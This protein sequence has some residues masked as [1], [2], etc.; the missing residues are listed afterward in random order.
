DDTTT[1]F[2]ES[3]ERLQNRLLDWIPEKSGR[4]LDVGCGP[5]ASTRHLFNHYKP[6]DVWAINISEKQIE[7]TKRNAPGCHA[8]VMNAVDLQFEDD[9]FDAVHSIE[10]AFH[11]ETRRRF[12]DETLRVLKPDGMLV[13]SDVLFS[14]EER[15]NHHPHL[16]SPENHIETVE[17][18]EQV[19]VEAG[20][21]NVVV[22]DVTDDVWGAH[23]LQVLN[24]AHKGFYEGRLNIVELTD[25]LWL[26]YNLNTIT[27]VCLFARGQK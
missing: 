17:A 2:N 7:E 8:Q 26:Y 9:F 6:N 16:P 24:S 1:S 10:A 3:C 15:F 21:R 18:Y 19:L 14:C 25:T 12:F 27:K 20:F 23:F 5:G 11:F 4:I 13:L 22:E